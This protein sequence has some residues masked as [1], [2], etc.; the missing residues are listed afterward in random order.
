MVNLL[1]FINRR[2]WW[3]QDVCR[4]QRRLFSCSGSADY[5]EPELNFKSWPNEGTWEGGSDS[6]CVSWG[7]K[8]FLKA[9]WWVYRVRSPLKSRNVPAPVSFWL[10]VSAASDS[11]KF[12]TIISS[13]NRNKTVRNVFMLPRT[14]TRTRVQPKHVSSDGR[15]S[16]GSSRGNI[17]P[18]IHFSSRWHHQTSCTGRI[19]W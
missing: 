4:I 18:Q 9:F 3:S 19:F 15:H 1:A 14:R 2:S 7:F 12:K 6:C 13:K 17:Y 10:L 16:A 5:R 11:K 8:G